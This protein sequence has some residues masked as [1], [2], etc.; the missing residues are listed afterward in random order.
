MDARSSGNNSPSPVREMASKP[1]NNKKSKGSNT[2]K[3]MS[4]ADSG[5]KKSKST[6][7]KNTES[8]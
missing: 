7:K 4:D 5:T 2:H 6:G 3:N 1:T 8:K